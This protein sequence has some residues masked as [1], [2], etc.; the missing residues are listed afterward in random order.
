M[1]ADQHPRRFP[2]SFFGELSLL[3][4][5]PRSATVTALG[6]SEVVELRRDLLEEIMERYPSVRARLEEEAARRRERDAEL[7]RPLA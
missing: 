5:K 7:S 3:A 6:Q 1:N 4:Q 2:G